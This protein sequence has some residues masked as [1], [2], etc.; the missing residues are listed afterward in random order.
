MNNRKLDSES[1][2][3]VSNLFAIYSAELQYVME[4]SDVIVLWYFKYVV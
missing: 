1:T 3:Y 4:N 2:G